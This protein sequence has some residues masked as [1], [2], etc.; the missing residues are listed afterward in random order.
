MEKLKYI[1]GSVATAA[2]AVAFLLS[3]GWGVQVTTANALAGPCFVRNS[4]TV[5]DYMSADA[6][7]V[8]DAVD[9]ASSG[10]LLK[11]AGTCTGTQTRSGLTQTVYIS[12]SVTIQ[13][14]FTNTN[15]LSPSNP[16]AYPTLLDATG[17]GR[18]AYIPTDTTTIVLDGLILA[19]GNGDGGDGGGI[20]VGGS[21]IWSLTNSVLRDSG[22]SSLGGGIYNNAAQF[23]MINSTL[24]S[25]TASSLGGG[26]YTLGPTTISDNSNIENNTGS[27]GGGINV[28]DDGVLNLVTSTVQHNHATLNGGGLANDSNTA[29]V[30]ITNSTLVSN[31][32]DE[33]G[34]GLFNNGTMIMDDSVIED[35]Q[36]TDDGSG[37]FNNN[38]GH[39]TVMNSVIQNNHIISGPL[40]NNGA[41]IY[42]RSGGQITIMTSTVQNNST[43]NNGG[44]IW[45]DGD[46]SLIASTIINNI[47]D[48]E[49]GG[50][51]NKGVLTIIASDILSN[52]TPRN[53]GGILNRGAVSIED[54]ELAFNEANDGGAIYNTGNLSPT[55]I[56]TSSTI[57]NNSAL[58]GGNNR[59]G[60]VLNNTGHL[61]L[62]NSTLSENSA[63]T[64]G[65]G[66][67]NNSHSELTH[68]TIL[69]NT[70]GTGT[71]GGINNFDPGAVLTITN[72]AVAYNIGTECVTAGSVIDNGYNIIEDGSCISAGT[73]LS[74]DPSLGPL[75]DNG[76]NTQTHL[77]S[78]FSPVIDAIPAPSCGAADDQ[79]GIARPVD[80][81]CDIGSVELTLNF[82]PTAV[83]DVYDTTEDVAL[84]VITT[85]GV[86]ANDSD[87][88]FGPLT[89]V[90][91][92]D[93]SSGTLS[94]NADG[95]FTYT[96]TL[97]F[98]GVD[99]FEYYANDGHED[100]NVVEVTLNVTCVNDAPVA[101]DDN[102]G[103]TEDITLSVVAPGVLLNDTDPEGDGLTAFLGTDVMSGTLVFTADGSFDY[104]PDSNFC[105]TDSFTYFANDGLLTSVLSA[106]VT[107]NV[108]CTNDV[109]V[110]VD[111][112]YPTPEDTPLTVA[113]PGVLGNDD[114]PDGEPLTAVLDTTVMTGTL[115]F[116]P[117]GSF[118]FTPLASWSGIVTFTYHITAGG[119]SSNIAQVS[120]VV[121]AVN[122]APVAVDDSYVMNEDTTLNVAAP[123]VL[124][125]DTDEEN[126][127]LTAVLGSD[128]TDGTLT[129]N[130]D[131][132]FDYT[133]PQ[134]WFGVATFTYRA[135]D[136]L[137]DSNTA[138]VTITVTNINDA[139]VAVADSYTTTEDVTL[140]VS[141]PGLLLNDSDADSDG[142]T[143]ILDTDVVNGVLSLN[144][145]GSFNYTPDANFCGGD[146]FTY[147]V[148]DGQVDSN[149]VTVTLHVT[150]VNDAPT[151]VDD[152]YTV[153]QDTADNVLDVLTNDSDPDGDSLS[154]VSVGAATNG[155]ATISGATILYT[156][157]PEFTG[158]DVFTYDVTDGTLTR[159]A[160][161]TITVSRVSVDFTIYLPFVTKQ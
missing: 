54:S 104:I 58:G 60:G 50:V 38:N 128:V 151:A 87:G 41:G 147:H 7:A 61:K 57:H 44:A 133:P 137:F 108:S 135:N 88:D 75:A 71:G 110:A 89:A 73:S 150:C 156:P 93:V 72:S 101:I 138:V 27:I 11:V 62:V 153:D 74:G 21:V 15:W 116:T 106:T 102:Y 2:I 78:A 134:D 40:S 123:G 10:D 158:I 160:T 9:A 131:G 132:S 66:L 96:P 3:L 100:S 29:I 16:I 6:Q 120:L 85:T 48:N 49:G 105:G 12:Q 143:A 32:T 56:I 159:T 84:V 43:A 55:L 90:L 83:A 112:V 26:L 5:T 25:N 119:D 70:I 157:D 140:I 126:D 8:Q 80:G 111:D 98:C 13:G 64:D 33:S 65:G 155:T 139:P 125:N 144:N 152:S 23:T 76:G 59:G 161:V 103:A 69:N 31:T 51:W 4:N 130:D 109:P 118:S 20:Y 47:A 63:E 141:A 30:N 117:D 82:T 94:L 136:G 22:S 114:N 28:D 115:V 36:A 77:P 42:N 127:P 24:I 145:D 149:T 14:G 113:A 86:L 35:N 19:N 92:T 34:A 68:V 1:F 37:I 81:A 142:L 122:D 146:S 121:G 46:F 129:L 79:I 53:G 154:L 95:S 18:V 67:L 39:A 45:N 91:D 99:S 107:L 17:N 124:D 52:S 148:N 97:N